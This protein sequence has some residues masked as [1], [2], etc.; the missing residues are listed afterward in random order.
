MTKTEDLSLCRDY[1][2]RLAN[3]VVKAA[4][5]LGRVD[6]ARAWLRASMDSDL[7]SWRQVP[8]L[9]KK[10]NAIFRCNIKLSD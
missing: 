1:N 2:A 3:V 7:L 5:S 10:V 8:D 4:G 9:V 6:M